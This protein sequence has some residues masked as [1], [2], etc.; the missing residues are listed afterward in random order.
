MN[1]LP[2][3][4]RTKPFKRVKVDESLWCDGKKVDIKSFVVRDDSRMEKRREMEKNI[5]L[6]ID[7]GT[8][9]TWVQKDGAVWNKKCYGVMK[10]G[11]LS[12]RLAEKICNLKILKIIY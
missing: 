8:I 5:A 11:R 6:G 10:N 4:N 3:D 7:K 9:R 1:R 2:V 12:M